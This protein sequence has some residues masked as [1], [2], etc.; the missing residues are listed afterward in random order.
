MIMERKLSKEKDNLVQQLVVESFAARLAGEKEYTLK[1]SK[2]MIY[3]LIEK[4]N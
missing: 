3:K 2:E 1:E 4:E